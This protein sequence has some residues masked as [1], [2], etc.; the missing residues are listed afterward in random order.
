[1][2]IFHLDVSTI[3]RSAGRSAVAAAAYRAGA[4]LL[5]ARTGEVFD[6]ARRHGIAQ[7]FI[8]AP[9]GAPAWADDRNALWNAAE[10][11]ETRKNSTV[12]REWLVA[13]PAELDAEA[14]TQLV[15]D[16]AAELVRRYGVAVDAAIHAPSERGDD[17]NH[18]AHLLTSTRTLTAEGLGAKTRVLDAAKTGGAE[19]EH[20]RA[21]WADTVNDALEAAGS[22]ERIDPRAKAVQGVEA[23]ARAQEAAQ[24]ADALEALTAA[25]K[26]LSDARKGFV[27]AITHPRA[28][29]APDGAAAAQSARA[30]ARRLSKRAA[31]LAKPVQRHEG[32]QGRAVSLKIEAR[33]Q[34]EAIA[35][36][37]ARRQ[38]KAEAEERQRKEAQQVETRRLTD[39]AKTPRA[40][41]QEVAQQL[42]PVERSMAHWMKQAETFPTPAQ[43]WPRPSFVFSPETVRR[44]IASAG[45]QATNM[46]V[47][48]IVRSV[49]RRWIERITEALPAIKPG[50]DV[51]RAFT[52]GHVEA[53][54]TLEALTS[55]EHGDPPLRSPLLPAIRQHEQREFERR[56]QADQEAQ[57]R[58]AYRPDP[59]PK[60][61]RRNE[62]G[63]GLEM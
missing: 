11:A 26:N 54:R 45:V 37:E 7:S 6:F 30:E 13:L 39:E 63:G 27:A 58:R 5:D 34:E 12:A 16:L 35:E 40:A 56:W 22:R 19:I 18:H 43:P 15:R 59:S 1:M 38:R 60:P 47:W 31:R 20:M 25:P 33:Q 24:E 62:P 28:A 61:S 57:A 9:A 10:A 23:A 50:P 48:E 42:N 52:G 32:P 29:L 8:A 41:Q 44:G 46:Q 2:A 36:A 3:S 17:R 49:M 14:R 55:E 21:W 51:W 4:R 53:A